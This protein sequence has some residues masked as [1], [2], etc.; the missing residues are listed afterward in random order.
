[1]PRRTAE[2]RFWEQVEMPEGC[3]IWTG[4]TAQGYG[5]F[6]IGDGK[7]GAHRY[8]WELRNGPIPDEMLVCHSCDN[9]VCVNPAHLFIGTPQENMDD[10]AA[11]GRGRWAVGEKNGR[12]K[13]TKE[14]VL[15]MRADYPEK[16]QKQIAEETGVSQTQVSQ[17]IR[18]K[19]WTHI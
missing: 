11:K 3:W 2:E 7:V 19:T 17:I 16:T 13:I 5:S 4:G 9:P 8:S 6:Y 14:A 1:M 15:K 10:K 12:A 18:R